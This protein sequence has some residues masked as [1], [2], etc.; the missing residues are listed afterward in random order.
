MTYQKGGIMA[1]EGVV[2]SP[3]RRVDLA[4]KHIAQGSFHKAHKS[5]K[6]AAS[7]LADEI[8]AAYNENT[9]S[10]AFSERVR[11]EKEASGAM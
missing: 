3:Q 9:S 4:L 5:K 11:R 2:T 7:T 10:F 8:L 6:S 1:R